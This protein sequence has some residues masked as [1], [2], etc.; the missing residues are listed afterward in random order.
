MLKH[1][2]KGFE[3]FKEI[4]EKLFNDNY[5]ALKKNLEVYKKD[6][7]KNVRCPIWQWN[8]KFEVLIL[9]FF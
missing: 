2:P 5:S 4:M 1:C 9:K 7:G 8:C 3:S 6:E